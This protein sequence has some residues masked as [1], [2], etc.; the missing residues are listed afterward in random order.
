[1]MKIG[2]V[3]VLCFV[4]IYLNCCWCAVELEVEVI[5]F[6]FIHPL[7]WHLIMPHQLAD[8]KATRLLEHVQRI[9]IVY[10]LEDKNSNIV[11]SIEKSVLS[12]LGN[13]TYELVQTHYFI[14]NFEYEGLKLLHS[15]AKEHPERL[16]LY[17]HGKG[18]VFHQ[19]KHGR[20]ADEL[21]LHHAVI[22]P[23]QEVFRIFAKNNEVQ[24]AGF[25][26]SPEGFVWFNYMWI[27][28]SYLSRC[29]A[30][31]VFANR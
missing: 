9:N 15:R 24:K 21:A 22:K 20:I 25:T 11:P 17:F 10:T 5:Y 23:W 3:S 8:L 26:C 16:F 28:G 6:T 18:M 31:Q 1:M 29:S 7:R 19:H 4:L 27:R 14:N 2:F 12:S 13:G 30:P